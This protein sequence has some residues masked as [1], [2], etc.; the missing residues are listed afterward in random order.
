[1]LPPTYPAIFL[2]KSVLFLDFLSTLL[3]TASSA[4]PKIPLCRR[5]LG[6]NLGQLQLRHWLSDALTT[7]LD[8]LEYYFS[9]QFCYL[10]LCQVIKIFLY[11]FRRTQYT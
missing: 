5:M 6:S 11:K 3:N 4:A 9:P 10:I 7:R 2:I 8:L 1:M